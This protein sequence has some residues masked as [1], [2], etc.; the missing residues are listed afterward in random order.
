MARRLNLLSRLSIKEAVDGDRV[1]PGQALIIPAGWQPDLVRNGSGQ[2]QVRLRHDSPVETLFTP[3]ADVLFLAA[4]RA[5]KDRV[6]AV[7]MTGMGNDG[8][9]GL[10][11]VKAQKGYVL[12]QDCRPALLF[13]G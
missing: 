3:S 5:A 11:E 8:V 9:R 7:I 6:L 13:Y 4:A 1:L 10:R 2:L 12:A